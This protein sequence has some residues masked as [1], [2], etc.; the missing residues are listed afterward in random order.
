M[1]PH[2]QRRLLLLGLLLLAI[3]VIAAGLPYLRFH[4]GQPFGFWEWLFSRLTTETTDNQ[5]NGLT[6]TQS[7][8][9]FLSQ[10]GD[11][12]MGSLVIGFWVLLVF[13]ILYAFVSA[14][15]RREL[16]RMLAFVIPLV[17]LLPQLARR[18]A[19]QR[20]LS[21]EETAG[22]FALGETALPEPPPFVQ[23]PP[24][25]L[26]ILINGILVAL[27]IWGIY[28]LWRRLHP[29]SKPQTVVVRQI[30]RAL[31][32]LDAGLGLKN[33]VIAC[34]ANMCQEMQ[35][36]QELERQHDMTPREFEAHLANAG[37]A[38][39]HIQQLTRLFENVRYG[40][41]ASDATI[42]LEARKCLQAILQ[43]Y[44]E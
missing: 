25:W 32:D 38:S 26:F 13:S 44:G 27:L 41:K 14:K 12:A 3:F 20:A 24:E 22:E 33:V 36:S 11:L 37:I 18:L 39:I 9:N 30:K 23:Q 17:I 19:L 8:S 6:A 1:I 43:A 21:G 40:A 29:K 31:T 42:E 7:N 4:P 28:L 2:R 5:G 16:L 35:K 15:F 10:F 34:Y